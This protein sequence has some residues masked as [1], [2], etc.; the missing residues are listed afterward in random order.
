MQNYS[1]SFQ[2]TVAVNASVNKNNLLEKNNPLEKWP[3]GMS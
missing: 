1:V 3:S 2:E